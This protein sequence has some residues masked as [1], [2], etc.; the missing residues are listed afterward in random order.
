MAFGVVGRIIRPIETLRGGW[1]PA[2]R[3]TRRL[4][5]ATEDSDLD[6]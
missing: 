5:A 4:F 3:L 6:T 2:P 1:V